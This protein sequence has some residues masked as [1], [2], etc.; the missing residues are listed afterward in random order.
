M[1]RWLLHTESP[2][3]LS[4][5][6]LFG[7][8]MWPI[9]QWMLPNKRSPKNQRKKK[10]KI[11]IVQTSKQIKRPTNQM[12]KQTSEQASSMTFEC[13]EDDGDDDDDDGHCNDAMMPLYLS[14]DKSFAHTRI[15][16]LP[17]QWYTKDLTVYWLIFVWWFDKWYLYTYS[18]FT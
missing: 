6:M 13:I 10:L 3:R 14:I 2:N 1:N 12:N 8:A 4:C 5:A 11:N 16:T 15:H 7:I 9:L 18:A 17:S